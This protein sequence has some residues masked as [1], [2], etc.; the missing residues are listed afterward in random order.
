[1]AILVGNCPRCG[2]KN[3]TFEVLHEIH[4]RTDYEWQRWYETF[5]MCRNCLRSTTFV[6]VQLKMRPN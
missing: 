4:F 3:M 5:C 2:A 6:V 1:M